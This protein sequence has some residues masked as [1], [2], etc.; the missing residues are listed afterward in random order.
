MFLHVYSYS[1]KKDFNFVIVGTVKGQNKEVSLK[2]L[3]TMIKNTDESK[4]VSEL[5][6]FE[7]TL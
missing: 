3:K 5:Y 2:I 1:D 6:I 4:E 7:K